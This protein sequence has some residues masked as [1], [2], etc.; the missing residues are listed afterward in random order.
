M[1][2]LRCSDRQCSDR[3]EIGQNMTPEDEI[4]HDSALASLFA[5]SQCLVFMADIASYT[6][7]V[8]FSEKGMPPPAPLNRPCTCV[9]APARDSSTV[10]C[11]IKNESV[12]K[13]I[14]AETRP[15]A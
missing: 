12:L 2:G 5:A 10:T 4:S 6:P 11:L 9:P 8:I 15:L 13:S 14:E 1:Y 3:H 7:L